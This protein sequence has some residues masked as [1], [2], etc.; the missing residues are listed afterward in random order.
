M[1]DPP[2]LG[3]VWRARNHL[4]MQNRDRDTRLWN[5]ERSCSDYFVADWTFWTVLARHR[6]NGYWWQFE[7]LVT[8]FRRAARSLQLE[9]L[10]PWPVPVL[11]KWN[12][13]SLRGA[14]GLN[15]V[16]SKMNKASVDARCADAVANLK[17]WEIKWRELLA[18]YIPSQELFGAFPLFRLCMYKCDKWRLKL[19]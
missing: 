8:A 6:P 15:Q 5:E 12:P 9:P 14:L 3:F 17:L 7:A 11:W 10:E 19:P 2:L 13:P 4:G 16:V 1:Q 18:L